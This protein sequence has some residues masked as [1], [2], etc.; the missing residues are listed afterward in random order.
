MTKVWLQITWA[1]WELLENTHRTAS[2]PAN[3]GYEKG[4][5][6]ADGFAEEALILCLTSESYAQLHDSIS[7][8]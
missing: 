6:G 7:T 4:L 8:P 5:P 3:L 2:Q 1:S